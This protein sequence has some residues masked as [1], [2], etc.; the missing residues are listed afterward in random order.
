MIL[1]KPSFTKALKSILA[2]FFLMF[3]AV[4]LG[5]YAESLREENTNK[6]KEEDFILSCIKDIKADKEILE[7][8]ID[9][10]IERKANLDTLSNLCFQ[11]RVANDF[12]PQLY[13]K[14]ATVLLRP[15]IFVPN[16]ST[17]MQM[18][19]T[20]GIR[21]IKNKKAIEA[22][23]GYSQYKNLVLNQQRFYEEYQIK[24][25]D[26]GLKIF[27]Q[28]QVRQMFNHSRVDKA[29]DSIGMRFS[30]IETDE[31]VIKKFGNEVDFYAEVVT[32][33]KTLLEGAEERASLLIALLEKEY[34]FQSKCDLIG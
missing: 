23:L 21:F 8:L 2:E 33:Y 7:E 15:E 28:N 34:S 16:E 10:N 18:T 13:T 25:I 12:V 3:L 19:Y 6:K 9:S 20:G 24:T 11:Y 26:M 22:I 31:T 29:K 30:L 32:Y 17:M 14:Y 4:F 27:N 5:F 1:L